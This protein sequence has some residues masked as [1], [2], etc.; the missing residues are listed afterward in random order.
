MNFTKYLFDLTVDNNSCLICKKSLVS[1][2][3]RLY[4]P[5]G[6]IEVYLHN[7]IIE[8]YYPLNID[9]HAQLNE[10]IYYSDNCNS[11]QHFPINSLNPLTFDNLLF[12]IN[13]I[14]VFQ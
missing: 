12:Q 4:C 5:E 6:H 2:N 14:N 10:I 1:H 11:R 7:Q 3:T 8:I 9:I 13:K